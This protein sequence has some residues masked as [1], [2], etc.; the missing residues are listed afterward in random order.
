MQH[1]SH[2]I[3]IEQKVVEGRRVVS[4]HSFFRRINAPTVDQAL[5][6]AQQLN[7]GYKVQP[8][9]EREFAK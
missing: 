9:D 1:H 2:L 5:L 4:Y 6:I 3:F 7:P 8:F